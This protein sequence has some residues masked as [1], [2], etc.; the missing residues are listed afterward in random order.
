MSIWNGP[1]T[2][3]LGGGKY[4]TTVSKSASRESLDS[5]R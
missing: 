3:A 4:D 2:F 1:S 5:P